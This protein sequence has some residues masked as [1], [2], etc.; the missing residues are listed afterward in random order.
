MLV[1]LFIYL[2][3]SIISFFQNKRNKLIIS[4]II[5]F[6]LAIFAGTRNEGIDNDYR[7]YFRLFKL[8]VNEGLQASYE[9]VFY[10]LP[11]FISFFSSNNY[12]KLTFLVIATIGV[13]T[14][15]LAIKNFSKNYPLSIIVYYCVFFFGHEFTTIRAGVAAGIYLFMINDILKNNKKGFFLKLAIAFIFH[16][17]SLLFIPIWFLVRSKL[18]IKYYYFALII[19]FFVVFIN[20]NI[21]SVL[22]L[23]TIIPKMKVYTDVKDEVTLNPFNFRMLISFFYFAIFAFCFNKGKQDERFVLLFKLHIVSLLVFYLLAQAS[24]VFSLRSYDL[25]STVQILLLPY[26]IQFFPNKTKL[27]GYVIVLITSFLNLYYVLFMS[28]NIKEYSSWLF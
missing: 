14:K 5:I 1:Y 4:L 24:I 6:I 19:S 28:N 11:K 17:S 12:I 3:T 21:L 9:L 22:H 26:L 20:F 23:E 2:L 7:E 15:V 16:Y 25:L 18:N 8:S 10:I 27:I 13:S